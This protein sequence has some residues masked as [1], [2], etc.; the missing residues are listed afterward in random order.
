LRK[1]REKERRKLYE[2]SRPKKG[3]KPL[4]PEQLEA[5]RAERKEKRRQVEKEKKIQKFKE[6]LALQEAGISLD[7]ERTVKCSACGLTGHNKSSKIC[8][9][10]DEDDESL[11]DLSPEI[12]VPKLKFPKDF[13]KDQKVVVKI[14]KDKLPEYAKKHLLD[15]GKRPQRKKKGGLS[16][17][18]IQFSHLLEEKVWKTLR[19]HRWAYPF[20]AAVSEKEIPD[21]Y[22]VVKRPMDLAS[23]RNKL[24]LHEYTS[25]QS[26]L[27]DLRVMVDNCHL[28][29]ET[30]NPHLPPMADELYKVAEVVMDKAKASLVDLEQAISNPKDDSNDEEEDDFPQ[31]CLKKKNKKR[32]MMLKKK[33]KLLKCK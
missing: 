10:Y 23:M 30:R 33:M 31:I 18:Q 20:E 4:A 1:Q 29:N 27:D 22:L 17:S 5:R 9:K 25:R 12:A 2:Q 13:S 14:K 24:K 16:Q 26:F 28:Y 6:R 19:A 32:K 15:M 11:R 7:D 21:Y 3:P 8:P